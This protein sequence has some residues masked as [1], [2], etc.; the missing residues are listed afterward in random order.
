MK[1]QMKTATGPSPVRGPS[2]PT[3]PPCPTR[4]HSRS[5]PGRAALGLALAF[6]L[7][8]AAMQTKAADE[9]VDLTP[10]WSAG[11]QI[12]QQ[13]KTTQKQKTTLA[14][15]PNP[16][17][18]QTEQSQEVA[19]LV[20]KERPEGG[21]EVGI[22]FR[23][24]ALETRMGT[25]VVTKFDSRS[26]TAEEGSNPLNEVLKKLVGAKLKLFTKPN[27]DIEKVEGV[28]KL[29]DAMASGMTTMTADMMK[30]MFNEDMVKQM[31]ALP[32]GLP[33]DPV[34]AGYE[35]P[36][37][38]EMSLG[39]M[40]TMLI[41]MKFK[42]NGMEQKRGYAVAVIDHQGTIASKEGSG[43]GPISIGAVSG[44]TTG[45]TW[46]AP[47]IGATVDSFANQ[48]MHMTVKAAGQ[49]AKV[50]IDQRVTTKLLE[51]TGQKK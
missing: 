3:N 20:E 2:N 48:V 4:S 38:L 12:V 39:P 22:E 44:T 45:R 9:A 33:K 21:F 10:K 19:L 23:A 29:A 47:D 26:K 1:I 46:Y 42:F 18:Q 37:K 35:W 8:L 16:I 51:L 7:P 28:Q 27:G 50:E 41:S 25:T 6:A 43:T 5:R 34:S 17:Q 11:Q 24:L 31:S 49:E 32:P 13:I 15:A 30:T 14:A 40:G 36:V